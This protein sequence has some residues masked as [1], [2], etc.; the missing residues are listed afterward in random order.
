MDFKDLIEDFSARMGGGLQLSPD[1]AGAIALVVDEM[2]LTIQHLDGL[3]QIA[4]I[5]EIGEPPPAEHLE[6]LY[7]AMLSANHL[8]AGT[9]GATISVDPES[10]K[11]MLCRVLELALL[12][13]EAF[14]TVLEG[15]LNTLETWRQ[16]VGEF[17]GTVENGEEKGAGESA[18]E[19]GAFGSNGFMQV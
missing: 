2:P 8:F 7:R 9:G 12:D 10:S 16:L 19:P 3:N 5:G 18:F 11:V 17:R 6:R 14:S 15:F 4:L 13:G 1:D